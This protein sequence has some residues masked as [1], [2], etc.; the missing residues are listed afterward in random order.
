ME[1]KGISGT[2]EEIFKVEWVI[3]CKKMIKI[4]YVGKR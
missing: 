3:I 4:Y 1:R 2:K